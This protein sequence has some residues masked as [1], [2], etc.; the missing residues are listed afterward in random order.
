[1]SSGKS[2]RVSL[3]LF[4]TLVLAPVVASLG[5]AA[6]YGAGVVGLFAPGLTTLY[7]RRVLEDSEAWASLGLSVSVAIAVVALSTAIALPLSIVFRTR[8]PRGYLSYALTLP[9]AIPGTVAGLLSMQLLGGAGLLSRL[10]FHL[11]LTAGTGD[12]PPLVQDPWAIGIVMTHTALAIPFFIFL[13]AEIHA[14]ERIES[15]CELAA[16]LGASRSQSLRRVAVPILLRRARPSLALL[17]VVVLGS[18]E[19]PLMLGRQSPQMASVLIWRK[20]ALFDIAQKPLAYVLAVS[21]A[22]V[23]IGIAALGFRSRLVRHDA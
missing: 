10:S 11:G 18:F 13:F 23:A 8:L 17:F 15:L 3:A 16:M 22:S 21:F 7:W 4:A 5:Y 2:D 6:L 14:S 20:Y 9:L 12:F 1:M 19:I